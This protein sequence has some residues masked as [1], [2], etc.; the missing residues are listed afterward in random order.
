VGGAGGIA[1]VDYLCYLSP[2]YADAPKLSGAGS[3]GSA[4]EDAEGAP[5]RRA[6]SGMS[7]GGIAPLVK[8]T[9]PLGALALREPTRIGVRLSETG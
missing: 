2:E 5:T 6:F 7:S 9:N 1:G 8:G 3:A 4:G